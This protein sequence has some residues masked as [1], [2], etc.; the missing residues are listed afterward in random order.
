M[1][2]QTTDPTTSSPSNDSIDDSLQK[3]K[4]TSATST[5]LLVNLTVD[6][7]LVKFCLSLAAWRGTSRRRTET[8]EEHHRE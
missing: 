8:L 3:G 2:T 5:G 7:R 6:S 1:N 4:Q